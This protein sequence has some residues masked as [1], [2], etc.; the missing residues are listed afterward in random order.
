MKKLIVILTVFVV[1][2]LIAQTTVVNVFNCGVDRTLKTV[3]NGVIDPTQGQYLGCVLTSN[4]VF[5]ITQFPTN[6]FQALFYYTNPRGFSMSF[7]GYTPIKWMN[8]SIPTNNLDGCIL[9]ESVFGQ[10]R[11]TQ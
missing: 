5:S 7:V 2:E 11:A 10:L 4:T 6:Y 1:I 3:V 9:F 8:G